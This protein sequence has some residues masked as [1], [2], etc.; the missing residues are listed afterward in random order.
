MSRRIQLALVGFVAALAVFG[1]SGWGP[2]SA[3]GWGPF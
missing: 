1:G 2:F 3:S